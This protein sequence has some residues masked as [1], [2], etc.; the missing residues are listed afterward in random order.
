M[1]KKKN[2]FY[3]IH[4][5]NRSEKLKKKLAERNKFTERIDTIS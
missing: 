3:I 2:L 1:T 4:R 5:F